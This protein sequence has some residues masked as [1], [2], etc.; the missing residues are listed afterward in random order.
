MVV[1]LVLDW[2]FVLMN[3]TMIL[4][5][6][7]GAIFLIEGIGIVLYSVQSPSS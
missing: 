7:L 4:C 6:E 5:R 1:V 3:T 2:L